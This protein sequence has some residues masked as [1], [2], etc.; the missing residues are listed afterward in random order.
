MQ[1]GRATE[2]NVVERLPFSFKQPLDSGIRSLAEVKAMAPKQQVSL[3]YFLNHD[4]F[5][6]DSYRL[7]ILICCRKKN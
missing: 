7:Y 6:V 4:I 5:G 3:I 1:C 2:V